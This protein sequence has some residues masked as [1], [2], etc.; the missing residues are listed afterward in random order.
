MGYPYGRT[1]LFPRETVPE[2]LYT[3]RP[4]PYN[5]LGVAGFLMLLLG[6]FAFAPLA[7]SAGLFPLEGACF[8]PL[9]GLAATL[10]LTRATPTII[11][12]EGIEVSRPWVV[13]AL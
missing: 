4:V 3:Y 7:M 2:P 10:L 8:L 5:E 13:R 6:T 12:A 1:A 11:T 9:L